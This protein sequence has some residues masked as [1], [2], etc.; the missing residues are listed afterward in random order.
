MQNCQVRF[1]ADSFAV[2]VCSDTCIFFPS[3]RAGRYDSTERHCKNCPGYQEINSKHNV[4]PVEVTKGEHKAIQTFRTNTQHDE[5]TVR[6]FGNTLNR[7]LVMMIES[8]MTL[9]P[10]SDVSGAMDV[11]A[12]PLA[13]LM[14]EADVEQLSPL[15][16]EGAEDMLCF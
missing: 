13:M 16:P 10:E 1:P 6:H 15:E 11:T 9:E 3:S 2:A 14:P 7:M 12:E 5:E 4:F 8:G